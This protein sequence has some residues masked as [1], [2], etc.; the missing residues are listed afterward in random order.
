MKRFVNA[1]AFLAL[2][3]LA[4]TALAEVAIDVKAGYALPT[5]NVA[6][7][8]TESSY[9]KSHLSNFVSGAIPLEVAGRYRFTPKFSAGIYF[10]YA[11]TF[12]AAYICLPQYSCSASNIRVGAEAVYGFMP[13]STFNPWVSVGSGWEWLNQTIV[14]NGKTHANGLNGW[15]WF[16]V[17]VGADWNLSKMFAAGP[18][19]GYFGG[20]YSSGT[21]DGVNLTIASANRQFHGWWQ[22]GLKGTVNL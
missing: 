10:Q 22:L 20:Q 15:E 18:Y 6:S 1:L 5:G 7:A 3:M 11:P 17:Q 2:L 21:V 12:S 16:N 13:D 8:T 19:V 9:W 4:P 14:E